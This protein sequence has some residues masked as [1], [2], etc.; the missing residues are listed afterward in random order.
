MHLTCLLIFC[1]VANRNV[2]AQTTYL[3]HFTTKNGLPSNHCYYMLQD[4]KGYIWVSTDAG[5]SRFDG[6][7]FENF[8]I[9]NGLPDNQILQ[10]KEDREGKIWFLA[11]NGK[12]SY[13]FNGKIYN[14]YNDRL[15]KLLK[16]NVVIVSFFQD[17]K[18]RMW[19]GTN[20]NM[21]VMW[22]GKS[23]KKFVSANRYHQYINTVVNE[24]PSG[25]IRAYSTQC[26]RIYDGSTFR[27]LPHRNLPLSFKTTYNLPGGHMAY[28]DR[29]GLNLKSGVEQELLYKIDP[30]ILRNDPGYFFI[31]KNHELWLSNADGVYHVSKKGIINTYLKGITCSQVIGDKSDNIWFTTNNGIYMLPKESERIYILDKATGLENDAVK[32]VLK[33][34][35]DRLW[36]GMSNAS[37]HVVGSDKKQISTLNAGDGKIYN[38]IRQ[39]ALDQPNE[40]IYF[41]SEYGLGVLNHIYGDKPSI[42]YLKE[43]D[44]SLFVIKSFSLDKEKKLALAL[45]SGVVVIED[46]IHKFEFTSKHFSSNKLFFNNRSY[47]V[48]F[49][50]NQDLWFS[51]INGLS[52]YSDG[53]V[54]RY[55]LDQLVLTNRINDIRELADGTIVLA[56]DGYGIICI[57]NKKITHLINQKNG[58]SDN[59]CKRLFVKDN[60]IWVITNNGVNKIILFGTQPYI[61]TFEYTS[62]LLT[63]DVN[64]LYIDHDSVYFATNSGLVYFHYSRNDKIDEA[65]NVYV[66][67]IVSNKNI[68]SPN[69]PVLKLLSS[70]N[71]ISFT[72]SAIDFQNKEIT[73]RYRLRSNS[74]WT[75]TKNRRLEFSSLEPGKYTFELSAKTSNSG[76]SDSVNISFVLEKRFWQ[77]IWFMILVFAL[78]GLAF[79]K[80]AVIVTKR[81]KN[82]EQEKLLLKNK[83]L[84]L[85]QRAL[86]AMM[87]PHFVFNVMNSI[88][89]YINTKDT[90]SA[91]KILTG[92][93]KLI[94]KNLEICTKSYISLEEELEYLELYLSLEKKRFG[95]KLKYS[96]QVDE[97]IDRDE[98]R[99]PS[100]LLQPYIENAIWHGIMP[101][102]EGGTIEIVMDEKEDGMCITIIDNGIGI[103]NSLKKNKGKH[104]SQGMSL[105]QE[106]IN[107]L[108]RIEVNQIHIDIA[109]QGNFGTMVTIEIP[110]KH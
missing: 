71:N 23:L 85:E 74:V 94:R 70:S 28:L 51:N 22:D 110:F 49:D 99:I 41:A 55:F 24:D 101:K 95:H 33:D 62:A 34:S 91:N 21:L 12:L 35:K 92:F 19:F 72:Y 66:S 20:K 17:S 47:R 96:I 81:Q 59:I 53:R 15:L 68:L 86:Q 87:N 109:Q 26:E 56:T 76:W 97:R 42:R 48:Y 57:K 77:T 50:R 27:L 75:E 105:T 30:A 4:S 31:N 25:E 107:L 73:Y 60:D 5:V 78:A 45:S 102:E 38:G 98:T 6:K 43:T 84:M 54:E 90:T 63:D 16:F 36:L 64:D 9:D 11:L 2:F 80:L 61:E 40:S 44:N 32:S 69:E 108:N 82:K 18:G 7:A 65:P 52:K 8:S 88:Q 67:S 100:M 103:D 39:L 3:N 14:E 79:Y 37:I 10:L 89:H 83:I 1:C 104:L 13:F 106:R 29:K 93:A 46:R 58:L